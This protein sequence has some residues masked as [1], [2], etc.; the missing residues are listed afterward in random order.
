M[1]GPLL[2]R[3][4]APPLLSESDVRRIFDHLLAPATSESERVGLLLALTLRTETSTE[5]ARLAREMRRRAEPFRVPAADRAVDL[6]GSGGARRPSFNVS[7]V[8]AFVVAAAGTPVVKHGNRS[9]RGLCGSSD[10]LTALGLPIES[11]I[12]FARASY[13][14][15]R[16]AFLHAPLFHPATR[17]VGPARRTLGIPTVFNR[18]GPLS[19]PARVTIQVVGVPDLAAA[20]RAAATLPHLGVRRGLAMASEEGCDE[21]SPRRP[22]H[23]VRWDPE[24]RHRMT[25]HPADYLETDERRGDWGPL[26]PTASAD[27]TER[28]LAGGG[29]ARRGAV[30]LTSGAALWVGGR[31]PS[32]AR[33]VQRAREALD[34]GGA[35]TLLSDLRRLA[36]R[37]RRRSEG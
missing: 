15:Y 19:N 3:L 1:I 33:G 30:L 22:T 4:R 20:V 2:D 18:L 11:S 21:F 32:L 7:T 8:S 10:L 9:S 24:G 14:R 28:L 36:R 31:V 6:C 16:I 35:E 29:G 23:V 27:E 37:Y 26:S 34:G 5:L 25:V 17:A 13:V 12:P